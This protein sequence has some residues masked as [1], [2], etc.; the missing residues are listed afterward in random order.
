MKP[1]ILIAGSGPSGRAVAD[2]CLARW[3]PTIIDTSKEDLEMMTTEGVEK[4]LGDCTSTLVLRKT[5]IEQAVAV[6]GATG[7]DEVNFEFC[8]LAKELYSIRNCISLVHDNEAA[9]RFEEADIIAVSR[10]TSVAHIVESQLDTG[11]RTTTDIGL[12]IGEIM[13]VTVQ[14][15]SPVIG[16]TLRLLR[17]QA[18]LLAA[19]Y[20]EGKLVVPH[21]TTEIQANDKCLLTGDPMVLPDIAEYFQRGSSEFPLQF[22]TRF[23][24]L[25]SKN[26]HPFAEASYLL[27]S[28]SATGLR[29]LSR[30]KNAST[31]SVPTTDGSKDVSSY[32]VGP[33][34]PKN[35]LEVG[36]EL[37]IATHIIPPPEVSVLQKYGLRS[38]PILKILE[39]TSEPVLLSRGSFPYK[40]ILL[41]VSPGLPS[42]R[43]A[44]LAVALARMFE[45]ELTIV[46]ANPAAMVAG[47]AFKPELEKALERGRGVASLYGLAAETEIVEGNPVRQICEKS[48][49]FD[50]L[51]V[52]HRRDVKFSLMKPDVS[53]LIAIQ[54]RCSVMV[55]PYSPED[56][57]S[58]SVSDSVTS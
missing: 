15:H 54:A 41:A 33:T 18:W 21:G 37:D 55:L 53:K 10:P 44:E 50:L 43:A 39:K 52:A 3:Q 2:R 14:P 51:V 45:S 46:G 20:R 9:V 57:G 48:G 4:V 8:R 38:N 5:P 6:V 31:L 19:I 47:E 26:E 36:D 17:P 32:Y 28:T 23:A 12:G 40:R 22:G 25:E 13:E 7:S 56:L 30:E 1:I 58:S 35:M 34:W 49:D 42:L 16:K 29:V 24:V 27:E 11:R